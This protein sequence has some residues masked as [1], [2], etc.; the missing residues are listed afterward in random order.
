[1][2]WSSLD[3]ATSAHRG[4][5]RANCF[6]SHHVI[7]SP[8]NQSGWNMVSWWASTHTVW[9]VTYTVPAWQSIL[10]SEGGTVQA[11]SCMVFNRVDHQKFHNWIAAAVFA[12]PHWHATITYRFYC[13]RQPIIHSMS[14]TAV[15]SSGRFESNGGAERHPWVSRRTFMSPWRREEGATGEG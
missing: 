4:Q 3:R 12:L 14:A 6:H 1:M 2:A 7:D 10:R 8:V 11:V 13:T 5:H 9:T 15:I